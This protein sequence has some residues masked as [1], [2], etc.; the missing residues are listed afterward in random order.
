MDFTLNSMT[1]LGLTLAV[2]IVIDDAIIVLE[3][4][5][6]FIEEKDMPPMEAAVRATR[7]IALAVLATTISLVII[8][9]PIAFMTGYA[10]RYVN[11]FGWTMAV[12][13]LVSMLVAFTL[14]PM[15][16]SILLKRLAERRGA[17]KGEPEAA[18]AI[19]HS[20]RE[21]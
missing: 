2:G 19:A 12:S 21:R 7:E 20:T 5:Y 16:S 4:I 8:F 6:R 9:V 14:T 11:Q 13:V 1:L 10:R 3:N 15:L 17:G 18:A